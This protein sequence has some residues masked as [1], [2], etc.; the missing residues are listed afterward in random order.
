L[1]NCNGHKGTLLIVDSKT[2]VGRELIQD[3]LQSGQLHRVGLNN[4][5]GAIGVLEDRAC[6]VMDKRVFK[7]TSCRSIKNHTLQEVSHNDEEVRREWVTLSQTLPTLDPPGRDAIEENCS[8]TGL[9]E[10]GD[11]VS[12]SWRKT[13]S[14]KNIIQGFPTD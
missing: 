7:K 14:C 1:F 4:D 6:K 3:V 2:G 12:P 10:E 9:I 8:L 11:P 5:K 13:F